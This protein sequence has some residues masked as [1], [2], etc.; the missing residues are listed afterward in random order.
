MKKA[1]A[2]FAAFLVV[3]AAFVACGAEN[4]DDPANSEP[5]LQIEVSAFP[6]RKFGGVIFGLSPAEFIA[7]GFEPGDTVNI[8]FDN[9]VKFGNLPFL[10]GYYV[11]RG[12]N[13]LVA[14]PGYTN[15]QLHQ[16]NGEDLWKSSGLTD[17]AKAAISMAQKGGALSIEN[18]F[19]LSY[20]NRREDY[21]SDEVFANFREVTAGDIK[22]GRLYRSASPCDN[23]H[24]RAAYAD[25]LASRS[26]V[27]Y[28][29]DLADNDTEIKG[30]FSAPGFN[31]PKFRELYEKGRV[32]PAGLSSNYGSESYMKKLGKGF[33]AYLA[34]DG[35]LLIHC[36]EGKDR[37]GFVLALLEA[38]CGADYDEMKNDY[39]LTYR[40]YYGV[41]REK[42]P[43]QYELIASVYFGDFIE[44]LTSNSDSADLKTCSEDY[45][46][47]CGLDNDQITR[48]RER[49]TR[50]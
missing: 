21:E 10:T 31:S 6:E 49:L 2:V 22:P 26:N 25:A 3:S 7:L 14:Y 47:S 12:S 11:K 23:S 35:A 43:E 48:L 16:N 30:Y 24:G 44:C 27:E 4:S 32:F 39:M 1:I 29:L 8:V 34:S 41:S 50:D 42:N 28:I 17:G 20:T 19:K 5:V 18:S 33:A 46:I 40:N 13:L 36:T 15:I 37:T 9:G 45:L 38:L